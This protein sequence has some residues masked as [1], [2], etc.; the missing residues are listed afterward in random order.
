MQGVVITSLNKV[1]INHKLYPH[2]KVPLCVT[3]RTP[4]TENHLLI[5][6]MCHKDRAEQSVNF[7]WSACLFFCLSSL[8]FTAVVLLNW[9]KI[10]KYYFFIRQLVALS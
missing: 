10:D 8:F 9:K 7:Q 2:H 3:V 5:Y 1:S 4:H 6:S